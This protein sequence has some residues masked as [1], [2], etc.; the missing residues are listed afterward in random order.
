MAKGEHADGYLEDLKR[1][2]DS[3]IARSG[4]DSDCANL[5]RY[6]VA[7]QLEQMTRRPEAQLLWETQLEN[8]RRQLGANDAGT[9]RMEEYSA[10][11]LYGMGNRTEAK[12]LFTHIFNVRQRELG[13]DHEETQ[14]AS[15]WIASIDEDERLESD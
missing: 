10:C 6:L 7:V 9:L 4:Q 11:N 14:W 8:A 5:A 12:V 13:S 1:N 3:E 15:R 2:L